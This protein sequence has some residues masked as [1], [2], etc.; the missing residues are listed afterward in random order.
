MQLV[1][2]VATDLKLPTRVSPP[3]TSESRQGGTVPSEP[4]RPATYNKVTMEQG[5]NIEPHVLPPES[6]P[7]ALH[8]SIFILNNYLV[9]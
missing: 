3:L 6:L 9:H 1:S 2:T 7:W 8:H 5:L 4:L